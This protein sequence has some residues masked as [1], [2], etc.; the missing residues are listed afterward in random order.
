M[1]WIPKWRWPV[2]SSSPPGSEPTSQSSD[3]LRLIPPTAIAAALV[4]TLSPP[5]ARS[6]TLCVSLC[7]CLRFLIY[8]V[9]VTQ[10]LLRRFVARQ[11]VLSTMLPVWHVGNV[12]LL[13]YC[14]SSPCRRKLHAGCGSG[15]P[16]NGGCSVNV[17]ES[18][19]VPCLVPQPRSST[20]YGSRS[21]NSEVFLPGLVSR[22]T[23]NLF[24]T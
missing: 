23:Q 15:M 16:L 18:G 14:S 21:F 20:T 8:K 17:C 6:G 24:K 1:Q 12:A 13:D 7:T 11:Q 22:T 5:L 19:K 9:G 3:T 2:V 10:L 4:Q